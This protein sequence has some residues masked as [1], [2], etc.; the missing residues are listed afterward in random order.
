MELLRTTGGGNHYLFAGRNCTG[1]QQEERGAT[2]LA[3]SAPLR[4][5]LGIWSQLAVFEQI[6]ILP[7]I[8]INNRAS[9]IRA[10]ETNHVL[11][12]K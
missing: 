2:V 10:P 4:A 8:D 11:L 3:T 6:K 7:L 1:V 12:L 9:Q 5:G